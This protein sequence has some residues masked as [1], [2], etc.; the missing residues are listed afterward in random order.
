[1]AKL[2]IVNESALDEERAVSGAREIIYGAGA[3]PPEVKTRRLRGFLEASRENAARLADAR[4]IAS[5]VPPTVRKNLCRIEMSFLEKNKIPSGIVYRGFE[6]REILKDKFPGWGR[7][8]QLMIFIT[9]RILA[10]PE[11]RGGAP[12]IRMILSGSPA[13]ISTRGILMGPARSRKSFRREGGGNENKNIDSKMMEKITGS[14]ILQALIYRFSGE[15]FCD[16]P[17]CCLYNPHWRVEAVKAL[18]PTASLC[19]R[20][21]ELMKYCHNSLEKSN[22]YKEEK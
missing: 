21:A 1:M 10:T 2:V 17:D 13:V 19:A 6:F 8:G 15:G 5:R 7:A 12:H 11:V 18:G 22:S 9:P 4:W 20:H 16:S 3:E 14:L